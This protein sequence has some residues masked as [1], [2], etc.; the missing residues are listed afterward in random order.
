[1]QDEQAILEVNTAFYRAFEKKDLEAM[2][3]VWSHG[4]ACICV[5]PGRGELK[6]WEAI[7]SSWQKI[8]L[9]TAYLEIDTQIITVN[10]SE[11]LA[12]VVLVESVLQVAQQRKQKAESMAT[13]IFERMGQQWYLVHH[14]G[15]PVLS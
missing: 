12:Y 10:N 9:N 8:F 5:H 14:H 2:R 1:M 6:G 15:S 3:K 7:E 11:N 13:N 4:I